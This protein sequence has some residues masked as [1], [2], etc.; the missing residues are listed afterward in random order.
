M[1]KK[2]VGDAL[3]LVGGILIFAAGIAH[4]ALGWPELSAHIGDRLEADVRAALGIGWIFGSFAMMALGIILAI[5]FA[6]FRKGIRTVWAAGF[7]AGAFYFLFGLGA[8]L[9]R[10]FNA[11]FVGF[12]VIGAIAAVG[13]W[14]SRPLEGA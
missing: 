1:S 12:M 4:G 13:T 14:L 9:L 10:S 11:H 5:C 7:A 8:G 6:Q 3:T 2:G